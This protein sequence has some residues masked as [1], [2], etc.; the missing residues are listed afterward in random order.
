GSVC[1]AGDV[2]DAIRKSGY[3]SSRN[4]VFLDVLPLLRLYTLLAEKLDSDR[5]PM[6]S[7]RPPSVWYL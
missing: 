3:I 2:H 7:Q 6:G 4:S 5:L 1:K